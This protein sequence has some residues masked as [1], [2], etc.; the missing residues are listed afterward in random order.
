MSFLDRFDMSEDKDTR[1]EK[2]LFE[3]QRKI[4]EIENL[5]EEYDLRDEYV[6]V[7]IS[8]LI[9]LEALE[10]DTTELKAFFTFAL[11]DEKELDVLIEFIKKSYQ[12]QMGGPDLDFLGD[13]GIS[14][15]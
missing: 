8:G 14:L 13:L 7:N 1:R 6:S 15:N 11:K 5:V 10:N 9:D 4:V 3:L 2:F 12:D